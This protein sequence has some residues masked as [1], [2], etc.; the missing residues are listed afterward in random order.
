MINTVLGEIS[1]NEIGIASSHEHIFIDMRKLVD[2]PEN[3]NDLFFKEKSKAS[4]TSVV[5]RTLGYGTAVV[6]FAGYIAEICVHKK[7][8]KEAKKQHLSMV[9]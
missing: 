7:K 4:L 6:L 1:E 3:A 9:I 2:T 8:E 5:K